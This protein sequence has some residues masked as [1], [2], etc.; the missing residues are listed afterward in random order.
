MPHTAEI[1]ELAERLV[2]ARR[3]G[4]PLAELPAA[5]EP[6]DAAEADAVQDAVAARLGPIGGYK[7]FQVGDGV[8]SRGGI[9]AHDIF[10]SPAR[11]SLGPGVVRIEIEVAF[12]IGRDLPGHA[13]GRPYAVAEVEAV[14]EGAFAAFE[15]LSSRLPADPKP[16][17]L[18]ALADTM[19][20]RGLVFGPALADWR[21]AVRSDLA[22]ALDIDGQR[23]VAQ[24]GGH[25]SGD[26]FH[27][28]VWLA[29]ALAADGRGLRAGHL[30]TTGAFGG[31]HPI[32]VGGVA[33][34]SIEGFAPLEFTLEA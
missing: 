25:P 20:N 11:A 5:L 3:T 9:I 30:V 10:A 4:R 7:V 8:G 28:V 19:A 14:I 23:V 31:S 16:S 22:I 12:R 1:L 6:H 21:Q 17:S 15:L 24:R 27:P 34:G 33:T 18:A 2:H 13:D 29:R 26:P 32:A